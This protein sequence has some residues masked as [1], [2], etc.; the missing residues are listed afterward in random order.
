M[1][2][3]QQHWVQWGVFVQLRT[4]VLVNPL[5]DAYTAKVAKGRRVLLGYA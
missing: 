2:I 5:R 3:D 1:S 4:I